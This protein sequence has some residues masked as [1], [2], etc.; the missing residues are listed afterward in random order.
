[1]RYLLLLLVT[2]ATCATAKEDSTTLQVNQI[3]KGIFLHTSYKMLDDYG[4]VDSNGL[5]L[6]NGQQAIIIDTPWSEGDTKALLS[7]IAEKELKVIATIVTHSHE[8]RTA[9]LQILNDKLIPT[10]ASESTNEI[11]V[12]EG[13]PTATNVFLDSEFPTFEGL[14]EVFYPG[15]GHSKDNL[16]IWIPENKILFGGCLVRSLEWDG[17][18]SIGDA[19]I[20]SW[21]DSIRNIQSKYTEI[22]TIVPGHGKVGD[23]SILAHTIKLVEKASEAQVSRQSNSEK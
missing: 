8:D 16:V 18:G 11:L 22:E 15:A 19:S 12:R 5:V 3:D 23:I 1:M 6:V 2:I 13:K 9:G 4:L 20:N 7:W 10:Y 17:L 14:V 21:A